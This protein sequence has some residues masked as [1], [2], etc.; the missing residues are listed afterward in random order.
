MDEKPKTKQS[1]YLNAALATI[2]VRK[3]LSLKNEKKNDLSFTDFKNI[4]VL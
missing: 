3:I 1:Y 4:E 2:F